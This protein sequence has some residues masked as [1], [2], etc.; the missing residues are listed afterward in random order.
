MQS[1]LQYF[2][3]IKPINYSNDLNEL[4]PE[5]KGLYPTFQTTFSQALQ[6][7]KQQYKLIIVYHHSPHSP[8]SDFIRRLLT[9]N[10]LIQEIQTHYIIHLSNVNTP[11]GRK[12]EE[13]HEIT[14]F[15]SISVVFP[16]SGRHGDV[17]RVVKAKDIDSQTLLK[18]ANTHNGMFDGV[19]TQRME[20]DERRRLR[21]QQEEEYQNALEEARKKE[22]EEKQE[23]IAKEKE[24]QMKKEVEKEQQQLIENEKNKKE[25]MKNDMLEKKKMFINEPNGEGC[26]SIVVRFPN[27]RK[28]QRKFL[29]NDTVQMIY[30]WVDSNQ[31]VSRNYR[32]S[33]MYPKIQLVN[34]DISLEDAGL[35]PSVILV[36]E[37]D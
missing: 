14:T 21:E 13:L 7:S 6:E 28:I 2:N 33:K 30:Y 31:A 20:E 3:F 34:K 16:F 35:S 22:E 37:M 5:F 12:L 36:L 27:G 1:F 25:A 24:E 29:K 32:L 10:L 19:R 4:I 9:D 18:I 23:Q 8:S 11:Q 26:C 15:P 17:L